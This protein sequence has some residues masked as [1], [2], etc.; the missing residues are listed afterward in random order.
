MI[1]QLELSGNGESIHGRLCGPS[2]EAVPFT[3]W[4]GLAA[5]VERVAALAGRPVPDPRTNA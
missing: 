3:G 4:L 2:G 1:L 5:A